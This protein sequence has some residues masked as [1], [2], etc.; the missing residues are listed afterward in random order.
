MFAIHQR[1]IITTSTSVKRLDP[2][3]THVLMLLNYMNRFL[4]NL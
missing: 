2:K 4:I 1:H 3:S